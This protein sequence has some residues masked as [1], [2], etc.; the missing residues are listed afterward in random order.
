MNIGYTNQL[1]LT[2]ELNQSPALHIYIY[3]YVFYV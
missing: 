2:Y 3:M 1:A